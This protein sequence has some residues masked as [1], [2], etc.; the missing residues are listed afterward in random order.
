MNRIIAVFLLAITANTAFSGEPDK[1]LHEKCLYP[2]I[3]TINQHSKGVGSGV[4][5][6][7]KKKED[8]FETFAFT[9]AHVIVALPKPQTPHGEEEPADKYDLN[10]RVG[11]YEDWSTLVGH[12]EY[13]AKVLFIDRTKDIS[14]ISFVTK[15]ELKIADVEINSKLYIGND[16]FRI[17]CGLNEPFR[18]DYG[19]VTS[20][21][22]SIGNRIKGT[23]RTSIPSVMGD[24]GGPVFHEY[25]VVG[26]VQGLRSVEVNTPLPFP[27]TV[28]FY[29]MAYVIPIERFYDSEDIA[30]LL[31][32]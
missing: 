9:C 12:K 20:L 15:T 17:G 5:I 11:I 14:L 8:G 31:K 19:K 28:P 7:I 18:L 30:K 3:M 29:N 2:S 1:V 22:D 25:K 27:V 24:S 23:Y 13:P 26:I 16:V 32:D 4:I 21:K 10:A 6:K